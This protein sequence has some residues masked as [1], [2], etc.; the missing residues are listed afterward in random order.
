M[1]THSIPSVQFA[2]HL[3]RRSFTRQSGKGEARTGP[4]A[5]RPGPHGSGRSTTI[6]PNVTRVATGLSVKCSRALRQ[7]VP[8]AIRVRSTQV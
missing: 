5:G 7:I 2:C 1:N 8:D 4:H 3:P 6:P